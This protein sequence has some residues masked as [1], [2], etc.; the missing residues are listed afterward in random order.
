[1]TEGQ[2]DHITA[3]SA[4]VFFYRRQP[5]HRAKKLWVELV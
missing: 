1:L 3:G 5:G 4:I 2:L